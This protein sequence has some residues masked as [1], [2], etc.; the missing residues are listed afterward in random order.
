[1]NTHPV[2]ISDALDDLAEVG[3][4]WAPEPKPAPVAPPPVSAQFRAGFAKLRDRTALMTC[5][6]DFLMLVDP[7]AYL[8]R[9]SCIAAFRRGAAQTGA[10]Q[11]VP[12]ARNKL[13]CDLHRDLVI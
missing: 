7:A 4:P 8:L 12:G 5:D 2:F 1:M 3:D 9:G 6:A 11:P 13:R 10:Y